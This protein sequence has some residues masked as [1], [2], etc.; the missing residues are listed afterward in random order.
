MTVISGSP[1]VVKG[2]SPQFGGQESTKISKEEFQQHVSE[3]LTPTQ[4]PDRPF[5]KV[6]AD[7][8]D[9]KGQQY[10][11]LIDYYSR[12]LE[13]AHLPRITAEVVVGR[14]KNIFAHHGIPEAVITDNGRQFTSSEFQNFAEAWKCRHTTSSPHFPQSNGE[15]ERAVQ[16][17]KKILAKQDP[18]FALLGYRA[19]ATMPTGTSPAELALGGK[20]GTTLPTLDLLPKTVSRKKISE[21]DEKAKHNYDRRRGAQHLPELQP[22]DSV[23]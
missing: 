17:V 5:Q 1:N 12:Y 21:Q 10:L 8:C 4:L 23:L 19:T 6:A 14:M 15:A 7:I 3:P 2:P 9:F 13:I 18:F 16:E 11:I 22:G 20:I